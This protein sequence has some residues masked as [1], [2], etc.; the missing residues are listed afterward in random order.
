M[1]L[2]QHA[3]ATQHRQSGNCCLLTGGYLKGPPPQPGGKPPRWG[4]QHRRQ[5]GGTSSIAPC[6]APGARPGPSEQRD[7][8]SGQ[9]H[10]QSQCRAQAEV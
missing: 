6:E 4:C 3:G 8:P 5:P 2:T 1:G 9:H 10:R 7:P